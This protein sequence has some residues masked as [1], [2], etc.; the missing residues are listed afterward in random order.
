MFI[1]LTSPPFRFI[2]FGTYC[3]SVSRLVVLLIINGS[4]QSGRSG[5]RVG[6]VVLPF[7]Q[8]AVCS[9]TQNISI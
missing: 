8:I 7:T 1:L 6:R 5:L 2:L 4:L 9:I 3:F